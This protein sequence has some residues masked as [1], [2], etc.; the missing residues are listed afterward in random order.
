MTR[1][2]GVTDPVQLDREIAA[3]LTRIEDPDPT[4]AAR[5][6]GSLARRCNLI[7][8]PDLARRFFDR[9]AMLA[10]EEPTM[11][12]SLGLAMFGDG[13]WEEGL[14]L[15]DQARWHLAEFQKFRRDFP[16]PEWGGEDVAGKHMLLWAEQGIGDQIMQ[17]RVIAQL[18]AAGAE[19][20]VECDPRLHPLLARSFP[21][22]ACAVQTVALP[23]Q[24]VQGVYDFHGSLFSAWRWAYLPRSPG[25]YMTPDPK[26]TSAIRRA[27]DRQGWPLNVG[28]SW[29]SAAAARGG[30]RTLPHDALVPILR[31]PGVTFHSLQ[32][33]TDAQEIAAINR[34]A[35]QPLWRVADLDAGN[36]IDRLAAVVASLDLV[37]STDNVTVHIAGAVGTPCWVMLPMGC[38]WRWGWT[39][40]RPSLYGSLRLFRNRT[41]GWTSVLVDVVCALEDWVGDRE[42]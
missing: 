25:A 34:L 28:V 13:L 5:A 3:L 29:R 12:R 39:E 15:Y 21:G 19:I 31:Q 16:H 9:A 14:A 24:L 23:P 42:T 18:R 26:V 37:I 4:A 35:G 27:W 36:D 38:D 20:T 10:P 6:L 41:G 32:Y 7:G 2:G 8:R 40:E 1:S 22:I 17:A 33:D 11:L 30:D